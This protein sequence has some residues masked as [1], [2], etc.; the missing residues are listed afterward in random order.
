M[1]ELLIKLG[2][3]TDAIQANGIAQSRQPKQETA[4]DILASIIAP[5]LKA[6]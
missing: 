6:E 5:P 2:V 3:L 1:D 4:D